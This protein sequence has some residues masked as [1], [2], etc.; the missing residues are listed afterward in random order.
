MRKPEISFGDVPPAL[1]LPPKKVVSTREPPNIT[2]RKRESSHSLPGYIFDTPS[3]PFGP[4]NPYG[5]DTIAEPSFTLSVPFASSNPYGPDT[6]SIP[7]PTAVKYPPSKPLASS[8]KAQNNEELA[9]C[10]QKRLAM[11]RLKV[12]GEEDL[13]PESSMSPIPGVED[14]TKRCEIRAKEKRFRFGNVEVGGLDDVTGVLGLRPRLPAIVESKD[15]GK[16]KTGVDAT[17]GPHIRREEE[18]WTSDELV[19]DYDLLDDLFDCEEEEFEIIKN[20]PQAEYNGIA[21]SRRKNGWVRQ[22]LFGGR[23]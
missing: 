2:P 15:K 22:M 13:T 8:F 10:L 9:R 7:S 14:H 6:A 1:S 23:T 17:V 4:S 12:F 21:P 16:E 5:L 11:R 18:S 3:I 20:E 19:D